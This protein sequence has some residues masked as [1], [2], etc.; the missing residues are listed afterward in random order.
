MVCYTAGRVGTWAVCV[1]NRH[2]HPSP[3]QAGTQ[4][5][6]FNC[7][8]P[9]RVPGSLAMKVEPSWFSGRWLWQ[10]GSRE[11]PRESRSLLPDLGGHGNT[12]S[13]QKCLFKKFSFSFQIKVT[14]APELRVKLFNRTLLMNH[15]RFLSAPSPY[16]L[17]PRYR[18][19]NVF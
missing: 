18:T 15:S 3:L 19:V 13:A 9:T 8:I 10:G 14:H 4:A 7:Q 2:L 6:E 12:V 5:P 11:G 17:F 16:F 1:L